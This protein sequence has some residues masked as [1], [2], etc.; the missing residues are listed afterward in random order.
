MR[1][2][3]AQFGRAR[4]GAIRALPLAG[5]ATMQPG[6]VYKFTFTSSASAVQTFRASTPS[7]VPQF[8]SI[9][10]TADVH[11]AFGDAS[12]TD[13]T[14]ANALIQPG[15]SWQDFMLLPLDT[16]FKVKGDTTGGDIY[17]ILS[18]Q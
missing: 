15:D 16:S 12:V 2:I 3:P 1:N 6:E 18:S 11:I 10:T 8:V 7:L 17:L 4:P 5:G 13:P 14:N 9:K